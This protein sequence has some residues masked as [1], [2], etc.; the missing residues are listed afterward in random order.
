MGESQNHYTDQSPDHMLHFYED[1]EK[2]N[3]ITSDRKQISGG[4]ELVGGLPSKGLK[5]TFWDNENVLYLPICQNSSSHKPQI[6]TFHNNKIVNVQ[7]FI[8][9]MNIYEP[10]NNVSK[11]MKQNRNKRKNI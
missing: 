1:L 4:W 5:S 2:T 3:L 10:Q 7:A 9:I 6:G 8:I 11:Y